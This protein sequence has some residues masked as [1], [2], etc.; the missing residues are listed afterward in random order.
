MKRKWLEI[1]KAPLIAFARYSKIPM[2]Q[3]VWSEEA[4]GASVVFFPW[5]GAVIGAVFWI[6]CQLFLGNP[7]PSTAAAL[8]L[9][10]VPLMLTGGF[11]LDGYMDTADAR[12]SYQ[13][14]E[15]KLE[16]LKD[17]RVGAFAVIG[18]LRQAGLYL[19]SLIVLY[20]NASEGLP[21]EPQSF[22]L[23][24][25]GSF[26]VARCLSA[27][28]VLSVRPARS[29]GMLYEEAKSA[30]P[31]KKVF[32]TVIL[33]ELFV[34]LIVL[35]MGSVF[36]YEG[37]LLDKMSFALFCRNGLSGQP[38]GRLLCEAAPVGLLAVVCGSTYF[39]F[40][41]MCRREFGGITGDLAGY[42][43][44][45]CEVNAAVVMAIGELIA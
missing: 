9:A 19:A 17:P 30:D 18:V 3:V 20:G 22:M 24:T 2:P 45:V 8:V 34:G 44:V 43:V 13:S 29:E 23:M 7:I 6:I 40:V 31:N 35:C 16:I 10:V 27:L 11:H 14:R 36:L 26:F 33:L 42:F 21:N 32:A 1:I 38:F 12:G 5:V 4:F 25:A 28:A 41:R 39:W 15:K 37:I